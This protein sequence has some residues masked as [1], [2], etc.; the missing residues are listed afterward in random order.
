MAKSGKITFFDAGKIGFCHAKKH[1][2][3]KKKGKE[4]TVPQ[5]KARF[6]D[7]VRN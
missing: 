1:E 5:V 4:F 7:R 2:K 6:A 3:R